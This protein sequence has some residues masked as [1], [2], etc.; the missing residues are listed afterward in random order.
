MD[1]AHGALIPRD[2]AREALSP[3]CSRVRPLTHRTATDVAGL[4]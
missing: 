1:R 3:P 4:L 2:G